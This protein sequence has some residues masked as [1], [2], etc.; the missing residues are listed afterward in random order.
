M[1]LIIGIVLM[2]GLASCGPHNEPVAR[3]VMCDNGFSE[4]VGPYPHWIYLDEGIVSWGEYG[5]NISH[6][7]Y[8]VPE[9]VRCF[10][11]EIF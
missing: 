11:E 5:S 7:E 2:V 4:V 6:N 9:G 1:R 3:S 8:T 10:K